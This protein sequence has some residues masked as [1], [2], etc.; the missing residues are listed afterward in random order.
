MDDLTARQL[1]Y[2]AKA[3]LATAKDRIERTELHGIN[4]SDKEAALVYI[5]RIIKRLSNDCENP[6][7]RKSDG[8]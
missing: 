1:N 4:R 2:L 8:E 5:D 6:K 7:R 3:Q